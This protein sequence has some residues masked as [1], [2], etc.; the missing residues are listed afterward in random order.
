ML[1]KIYSSY[2][3]AG[4]LDSKRNQVIISEEILDIRNDVFDSILD[5]FSARFMYEKCNLKLKFY[6]EIMD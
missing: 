2:A 4:F 3:K 6:K 5:I 1:D